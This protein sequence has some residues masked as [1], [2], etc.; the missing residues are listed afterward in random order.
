MESRNRRLPS[1]NNRSNASV[2]LPEP[3]TPVITTNFPRGISRE[4]FF[5]L[6]SRAPKM[7][8]ASFAK[9]VSSAS[10]TWRKV[11]TL[12][13]A[14]AMEAIVHFLF[15]VWIFVFHSSPMSPGDFSDSAL[16]LIGHGSTLNAESAKPT[17]QHA[18][19]FRRRGM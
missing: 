1:A 12:I 13:G 15:G 17:Y 5:K 7:R 14:S 18:D 6:C 8:M 2:L 4:K 11:V 19:E 9:V 10:I 16:V 3:L